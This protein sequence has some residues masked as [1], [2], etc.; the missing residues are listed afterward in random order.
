[1]RRVLLISLLVFLPQFAFASTQVIFLTS[2]TIWAVPSDWNSTSNTIEV[3]GAGGAGGVAGGG[4]GAYSKMTNLT[5]SPDS[6]VSYQVGLGGTSDGGD[7]YFN[8]GNCGGSSVCAKGGQSGGGPPG[9]GAGGGGAG[10]SA[11]DGRGSVKY[12]GGRGGDALWAMEDDL[13]GSGGG[14]AG[15]RGSGNAGGSAYATS[16]RKGNVDWGTSSGGGSGDAGYGGSGGLPTQVGQP[17]DGTGYQDGGAGTEWGT[18]GSGGGGGGSYNPSCPPGYSVAPSAGSGGGFGGG[19]GGS[20]QNGFGGGCGSLPG[21]GSSGLIVITYTPYVNSPPTTPV[22]T[23]PT[24]GFTKTNYTYTFRSTD[25]DSDTIRYAIDWDDNGSIDEYIPALGYVNSGVTSSVSHSWNTTGTKTFKVLAQDS[26]TNNSGWTSYTVTVADPP[27]TVLLTA[28]PSSI[29]NGQS[30]TLMWSSSYATS[31]TGTNFSTG[32][33]ANNTSPGVSVSPTVTTTYT[34]TCTGASGTASDSETVT[35]T[36]TPSN[37][38]SGRNVVN[39]CTGTIVQS[40]AYQCGSGAC[41]PPPAP[42]PNPSGSGPA[43]LTGHLQVRPPLVRYG[44]TTKVYWNISN[45][46]SCTVTGD[47]NP[48]DTWTVAGTSGN[49]WTSASGSEGNTSKA[50]TGPTTY[51]LICTPFEGESFASETQTVN[52]VPV[53]REK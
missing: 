38:C 37:I 32:G 29:T 16:Y 45:V 30:S 43:A 21:N 12:S 26:Q 19:G 13:A 50:I 36:C 17:N 47:N 52:L 28:S 1:M 11:N 46:S 6:S 33:A 9:N 25:P 5:L 8:G 14:A 39:S 2:G 49:D 53:F 41:I 48:P 4:G 3:V 51:T 40:C 15:P 27:P 24:S 34:I 44:D 20:T 7:T 18:H 10:G 42:A 22:I 35:F 31:C 23:G